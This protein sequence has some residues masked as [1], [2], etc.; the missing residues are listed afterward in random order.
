MLGVDTPAVADIH[1]RRELQEIHRILLQAG[2]VIVEGL[3]NL[4]S[5]RK[6]CF[7][8]MVF[9]LKVVGGDGSPARAVAIED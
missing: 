9:P 6:E 8:L 5:I 2:V 7:T 1:N 4:D 3:T